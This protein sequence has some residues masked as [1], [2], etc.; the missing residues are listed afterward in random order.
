M[1]NWSETWTFFNGDWH[2]GNIPML[3][4]RTHA[5]WL[6]SSVF[7]GA[8]AFEGVTPD[9]DR[10]CERVNK[11]AK[12]LGLNPTKTGEEIY[13][14]ARD[15]V[16]KFAPGAE[17]YI[18][19]MYW[20]EGNGPSAVAPDPDDIGFCVSL[21]V[22]PMPEPKGFSIT[23]APFR[24][25]HPDMAPVD[26]KAGCL[27]PNPARALGYARERGFDNAIMLDPDG[28]VAE[29]ATANLW[30]VKDGVAVTPAANGT[31]LAGITRSRV[32]QLLRDAGVP[33]V[34]RTVSV[35]EVLEADEVFSSGNAGKVQPITRVGDRALQPGPMFRKARALY[36][37]FAHAQVA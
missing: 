33:V 1:A 3:G 20:G 21:Y 9:L 17:L 16:K 23:T 2:Q 4:V 12:A 7:D 29:L 25:P 6:G 8:R 24:R 32:A 28:N 27:Y 11:S 22:A 13:A 30:F 18:R 10:H 26:A 35:G 34:E 36:W 37:E 5:T 14:I 31:F 19:P 15:G